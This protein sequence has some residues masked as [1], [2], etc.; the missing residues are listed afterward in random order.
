VPP[1]DALADEAE[2][3][4]GFGKV[5]DNPVEIENR[6]RRESCIQKP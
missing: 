2:P 5:L 6:F 3:F 1:F 4:V